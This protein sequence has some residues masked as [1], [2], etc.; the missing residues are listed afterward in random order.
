M[1]IRRMLLALALALIANGCVAAQSVVESESSLVK[2]CDSLG[3]AMDFAEAIDNFKNGSAD[4]RKEAGS[5]ISDCM[6]NL[7]FSTSADYDAKYVLVRASVLTES[8]GDDYASSF[9]MLS[10]GIK[11][12]IRS[13]FE[14]SEVQFDASMDSVRV[15]TYRLSCIY[16]QSVRVCFEL[17][18]LIH[19]DYVIDSVLVVTD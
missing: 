5:T 16:P 2:Y 17:S 10:P 19:G 13:R 7:Y 14:E 3:L 1:K 8:L 6:P 15:L 9:D 4:S 11:E 12:S 18:I